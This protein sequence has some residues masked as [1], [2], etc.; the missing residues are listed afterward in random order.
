MALHHFAISQSTQ[1]R[2]H[3]RRGILTHSCLSQTGCSIGSSFHIFGNQNEQFFFATS[4]IFR[5]QVTAIH[6]N[7]RV[8]ILSTRLPSLMSSSD[9]TC[10][11]ARITSSSMLGITRCNEVFDLQLGRGCRT[12]IASSSM[13]A[14]TVSFSIG[15]HSISPLKLCL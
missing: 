7:K 4:S 12:S 5:L 8:L 11:H 1:Q 13:P 2:H 10:S 6:R 14:S 3:P 9:A 15:M